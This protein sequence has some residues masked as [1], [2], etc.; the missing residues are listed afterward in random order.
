MQTGKNATI[1]S[2]VILGEPSPPHKKK[3]QIPWSFKNVGLFYY[4]PS[5]F[6]FQKWHLLWNILRMLPGFKHSTKMSSTHYL[7]DSGIFLYI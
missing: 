3:P 4:D 1:F 2:I 7:S 6:A 5:I